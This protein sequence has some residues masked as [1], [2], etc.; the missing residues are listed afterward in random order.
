MMMMMTRAAIA[1]DAINL[2]YTFSTFY[3][4]KSCGETLLHICVSNILTQKQ[5]LG[6]EICCGLWV[7]RLPFSYT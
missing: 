3:I 2:L 5:S 1:L 7:M 6:A 4:S